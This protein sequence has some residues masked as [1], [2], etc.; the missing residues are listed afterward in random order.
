MPTVLDLLANLLADAPDLP[1]A[2]CV[3]QREVFD[4]TAAAGANKFYDRAIRICSG[5]PA[6]PQCRSW[7]SGLRPG[8]P[9]FGVVGGL[10]RRRVQ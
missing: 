6:L 1:G 8:K 5:C 2:A 9:P 10:V 3:D 7:A 4:A